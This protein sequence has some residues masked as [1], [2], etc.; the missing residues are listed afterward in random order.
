M[1]LFHSFL[2]LINIPLCFSGG[3]VI[4]NPTANTGDPSSMP[5]LGRSYGEGIGD[6]LQYSCL[7]NPMGREEWRATVHGVTKELDV[8]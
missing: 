1:A 7:G 6:L 2:W 5:E 3:S 8:T 4:K